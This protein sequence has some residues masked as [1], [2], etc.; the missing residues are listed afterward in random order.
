MNE[1]G[2]LVRKEFDP[3][4]ICDPWWS[5]YRWEGDHRIVAKR[6]RTQD[7]AHDLARALDA[8]KEE[9]A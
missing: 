4:G 5:V 6:C 1:N 9:H 2:W 8:Q 7:E 3:L